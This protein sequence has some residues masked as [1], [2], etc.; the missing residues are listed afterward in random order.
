MTRSR[1]HDKNGRG[2]MHANNPMPDYDPVR[3]FNFELRMSMEASRVKREK[4]RIVKMPVFN[5]GKEK[6]E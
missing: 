3:D 5:S 4:L 6:A 2:H 1:S